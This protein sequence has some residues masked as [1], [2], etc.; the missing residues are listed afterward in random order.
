MISE[1]AKKQIQVV[2]GDS[3]KL[4]CECIVIGANRSLR[5]GGGLDVTMN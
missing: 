4:Y 2:H 1:K 3:N 5:G